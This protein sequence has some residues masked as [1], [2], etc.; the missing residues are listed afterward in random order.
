MIYRFIIFTLF[1]RLLYMD[2]TDS[3]KHMEPEVPSEYRG[4]LLCINPDEQCFFGQESFE[5][6]QNSKQREGLFRSACSQRKGGVIRCCPNSLTNVPYNPGPL[7]IPHMVR[8]Q[9]LTNLESCP[10]QITGGCYRQSKREWPLCIQNVCNDAGYRVASNYYEVC[11][12]TQMTDKKEDVPDCPAKGCWGDRF[13]IPDE[14]DLQTDLAGI[15]GDGLKNVKGELQ[16]LPEAS[17]SLNQLK[18]ERQELMKEIE[19][20]KA[21]RDAVY[22]QLS[23]DDARLKKDALA[24][25]N[26]AQE[27]FAEI[28]E[29]NEI[30]R[31]LQIKLTRLNYLYKQ[32][33]EEQQYFDKRFVKR[34]IKWT[35]VLSLVVIAIAMLCLQSVR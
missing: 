8:N 7:D 1:R 4:N 2:K 29:L 33:V 26:F 9:G 27:N 10:S 16:K 30:D 23:S 24:Q 20:L 3:M 32:Q 21:K 5:S 13:R 22:N 15:T 18:K 35:I 31:K 25:E 6:M 12:A 19:L 11:K 28:K 34:Y 17:E 14:I